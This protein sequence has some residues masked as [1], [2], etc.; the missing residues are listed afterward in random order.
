MGGGVDYFS[1]LNL[2]GAHGL[3]EGSQESAV[4]GYLTDLITERAAASVARERGDKPF[5]LSVHYTAPHRPW[6]SC[7]DQSE[8]QRIGPD[9]A[10]LDNG[11]VATYRKM[12]LLEGDPH[13]AD[14][15][16]AG[17][18]RC[19]WPFGTAHTD[20]RLDAH[21]CS[22]RQVLRPTWTVRWTA[23]A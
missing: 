22:K 17:S 20:D 16:V 23:S 10:H 18:D 3:W 19:R 7:D 15:T 14:R 13:S 4:H 11:S 9:I 2:S 1:H 5:L 12:D 6:E 21:P 8:S